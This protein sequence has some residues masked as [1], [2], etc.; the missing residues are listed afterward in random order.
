M[1]R[2]MAGPRSSLPPLISPVPSDDMIEL[3]EDRGEIVWVLGDSTAVGR[4][5]MRPGAVAVVPRHRPHR[6]TY[7]VGVCLRVMDERLR[8]RKREHLGT[9]VVNADHRRD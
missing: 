7:H 9:D 4:G 2:R 6:Q 8:V 3:M 5:V 1:A